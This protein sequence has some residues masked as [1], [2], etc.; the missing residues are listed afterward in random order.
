[1]NF[2]LEDDI[3]LLPVQRSVLVDSHEALLKLVQRAHT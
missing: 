2:G 1:M 3:A